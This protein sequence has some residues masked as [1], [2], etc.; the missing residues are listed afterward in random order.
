[1]ISIEVMGRQ[2]TPAGAELGLTYDQGAETVRFTVV[3]PHAAVFDQETMQAAVTW[4][5][6]NGEGGTSPLVLTPTDAGLVADWMPPAQALLT[7]G[8]LRA[9]LRCSLLDEVVW[10]SLPLTLT[11]LR[12][13]E[14]ERGEMMVIPKYKQVDVAVTALPPGSEATGSVWQNAERLAFSLGIP[15][16]PGLQ[17]ERGEKGE[18]GLQG[19]QG[20]Q[21]ETGA[22][23][24]VGPQGPMGPEGQQGPMGPQGPVGEGFAIRGTYQSLAALAAAIPEPQQG[25]FYQVGEAAPYAMYMW[26]QQDGLWLNQGM[27]Q[28]IPGERGEK[29]E[30]GEPGEAGERG[31]K[32]EAGETGAQGIPGQAGAPGAGL[33][34]GGTT[35][36]VPRKSSNA[37]Y[38]TAWHTLTAADVSALPISG[39]T[40]TGALVT[41]NTAIG[42]AAARNITIQ[43]ADLTA[44][45]SALATGRV[46]I[47]Y[48]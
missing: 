25:W 30:P 29:G 20:I 10:H 24:P 16:Q 38:A 36:Q 32:G 4:L 26:S 13:I 41:A 1:M 35:G 7:S 48:E 3:A 6:P 19:E 27:L 43:T 39:G 17:G 15:L 47:V 18:R 40:M 28:G 8:A 2:M 42:T 14:D 45:S 46:V 21:G 12:S 5:A 37:N 34:T 44:G 31:E 33:P 11:V 23:G 9:E 22:Q